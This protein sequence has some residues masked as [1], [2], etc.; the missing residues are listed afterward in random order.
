MHFRDHSMYK[1]LCLHVRQ[2]F[3]ITLL[4]EA[5]I[6]MVLLRVIYTL[7]CSLASLKNIPLVAPCILFYVLFNRFMSRIE[8]KFKSPQ[9]D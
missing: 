3:L 8:N 2:G 4:I 9:S 6:P 1:P 5:I 7:F